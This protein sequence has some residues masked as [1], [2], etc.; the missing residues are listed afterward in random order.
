MSGLWRK[1]FVNFGDIFQDDPIVQFEFVHKLEAH[2]EGCPAQC[3]PVSIADIRLDCE[4]PDSFRLT[5]SQCKEKE[6]PLAGCFVNAMLPFHKG[7]YFLSLLFTNV[8]IGH[9]KKVR[10]DNVTFSYLIVI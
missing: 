7:N 9:T 8:R 5:H 6:I 1:G 10:L 2:L 4:R 3:N